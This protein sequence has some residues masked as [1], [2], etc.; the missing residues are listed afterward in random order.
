MR[1]GASGHFHTAGT[2]CQTN[3]RRVWILDRGGMSDNAGVPVRGGNRKDDLSG[4]AEA[5]P[6]H[7]DPSVVSLRHSARV[8]P[9]ARRG[10]SKD[11]AADVRQV[12]YS[13]GLDVGD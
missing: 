5:V 12:G 4:T 3:I 8:F 13:A 11:E 7:G 1:R 6:F 10:S 9:Q 2:D